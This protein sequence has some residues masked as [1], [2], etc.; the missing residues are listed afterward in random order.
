MT[1]CDLRVVYEFVPAALLTF[2]APS[3][4][5]AQRLTIKGKSHLAPLGL[6]RDSVSNF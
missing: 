4:G 5:G 2:Q 1:R 3:C 6:P